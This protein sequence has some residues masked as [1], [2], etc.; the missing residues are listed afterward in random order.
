MDDVMLFLGAGLGALIIKKIIKKTNSENMA[1]TIKNKKIVLN[2]NKYPKKFKKE[3][4]YINNNKEDFKEIKV[5]KPTLTENQNPKNNLQNNL[6]NEKIISNESEVINIL[7]DRISFNTLS[8]PLRNS[9]LQ[10]RSE[11]PN[12]QV[13]VT[14]FYQ[15]TMEPDM[16]RRVNDLF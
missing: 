3:K 5:N 10:L 2:K 6:Q 16:N 15:T 11:P 7:T 1:D 14:P 13:L 9:N 12:P 4:K 8:Q